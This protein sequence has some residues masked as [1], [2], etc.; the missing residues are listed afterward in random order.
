MAMLK[1]PDCSAA[2]RRQKLLGA[3]NALA[4]PA[5]NFDIIG[6]SIALL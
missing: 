3:A 4:T 6:A 1:L 2:K 5:M